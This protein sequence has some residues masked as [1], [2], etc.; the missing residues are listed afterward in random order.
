MDYYF[1]LLGFNHLKNWPE[2]VVSLISSM[3]YLHQTCSDQGLQHHLLEGAVIAVWCFNYDAEK[4][5]KQI[6]FSR[7]RRNRQSQQNDLLFQVCFWLRGNVVIDFVCDCR[8][9]TIIGSLKGIWRVQGHKGHGVMS[10]VS[11][12]KVK[13]LIWCRLD[14]QGL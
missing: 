10:R 1:F 3:F 7:R 6:N 4:S 8:F 5:R 13:S 11:S 2:G 9:S 12:W 14:C